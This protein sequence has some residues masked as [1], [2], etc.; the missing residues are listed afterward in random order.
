MK[1]GVFTQP[2]SF[3]TFS[4][5]PGDVGYFFDCVAKLESCRATNFR[6]NQKRDEVADSYNLN[7]ATEVAYEFNVRR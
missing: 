3:A 2:G 5:P 1:L 7:R 6:E 4:I